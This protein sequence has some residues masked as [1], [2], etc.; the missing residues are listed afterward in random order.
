MDIQDLIASISTLTNELAKFERE[1]NVG[2]EA[3]Y[4]LYSQG[5]LD[6]GGSEQ[7]AAFCEWAGLYQLKVK[8]ERQL[9]EASRH[10]IADL[11]IKAKAKGESITLRPKTSPATLTAGVA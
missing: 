1:Y 11:E 2:S 4:E 7:T 6:D 9:R 5:K 8:R 3:F 10:I